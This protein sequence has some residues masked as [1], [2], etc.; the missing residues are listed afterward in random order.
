M[1]TRK[2]IKSIV[3]LTVA[4][5]VGR[6]THGVIA[7]TTGAPKNLADKAVMGTS[8][9]VVGGFVAEKTAPYADKTVDDLF[10]SIDEIKAAFAKK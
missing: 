1:I 10:E 2:T 3:R 9:L 4:I 6:V 8:A 7:Q 5:G